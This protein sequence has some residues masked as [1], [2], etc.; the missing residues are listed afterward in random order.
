MQQPAWYMVP[1]QGYIGLTPCCSKCGP[2][3]S[4]TGIIWEFVKTVDSWSPTLDLLNWNPHLN[5]IPRFFNFPLNFKRQ[6]NQVYHNHPKRIADFPAHDQA[7]LFRSANSI[8]LRSVHCNSHT[9][10]HQILHYLACICWVQVT[11]N[12]TQ[13]S[14]INREIFKLDARYTSSHYTICSIFLL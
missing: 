2:W 3:I 5:K 8:S 9:Y 14:L 13:V 11:K 12:P 7:H 6:I 1:P 10:C 4:N